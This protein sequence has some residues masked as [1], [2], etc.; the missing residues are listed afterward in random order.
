MPAGLWRLLEVGRVIIIIITIIITIII[1]RN[2]IIIIIVIV[3]TIII[4]IAV[5]PSTVYKRRF[6]L[7]S[8]GIRCNRA[9]ALLMCTND[10]SHDLV[11][12]YAV[13]GPGTI[14]LCP[15]G[16]SYYLLRLDFLNIF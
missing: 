14:L 9:Q 6:S 15:N 1:I 3:I 12:E 7:L 2:A 8:T 10:A 16:A 5:A 13:V 11:L 4:I